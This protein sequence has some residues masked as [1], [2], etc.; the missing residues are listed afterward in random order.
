[1]IPM[2]A[3]IEVSVLAGTTILVL[4]G[5][6][7]WFRRQEKNRD[8]ESDSAMGSDKRAQRV[9]EAPTSFEEA[10]RPGKFVRLDGRILQVIGPVGAGGVRFAFHRKMRG[11]KRLRRSKH[12]LDYLERLWSMG[13]LAPCE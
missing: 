8:I 7:V 1:M 11:R 5:L 2:R 6:M 12:T 10:L 4:L 13:W 3:I 9:S